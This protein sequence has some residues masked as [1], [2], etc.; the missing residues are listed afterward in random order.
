MK[1]CWAKPAASY[2]AP[3]DAPSCFNP[4]GNKQ[5]WLGLRLL[6]GYA[7]LSN[8]QYGDGKWAAAFGLVQMTYEH[9]YSAGGDSGNSPLQDYAKF[10]APQARRSVIEALQIFQESGGRTPTFGTYSTWPLAEY[11][12]GKLQEGVLNSADWP[13]TQGMDEM[14]A[15]L[16]KEPANGAQVPA[17]LGPGQVALGLGASGTRLEGPG[18][19]ISYNLLVP[20]TGTYAISLTSTEGGR[21]RACVNGV[22]VLQAATGQPHSLPP[23]FLTQGLH[24]L[25][26]VSTGGTFSVGEVTVAQAGALEGRPQLALADGDGRATASW[27]AVPGASGYLLGYGT[28][29]G[30]P[31]TLM[32]VGSAREH[33]LEGLANG[34]IYH[35]VV[36]AEKDGLLSLPSPEKSVK[37][38]AEGGVTELAV[39]DFQGLQGTEPSIEPTLAS[40]RATVSPLVRGA[41][42]LPPRS[43]FHFFANG[44]GAEAADN[45]YGKT[46]EEAVAGNDY[47]EFTVTPAPGRRLGLQQLKVYA[48]FQN[49]AA[50]KNQVGLTYHVEGGSPAPAPA[51]VGSAAGGPA[52]FTFDLAGIPALQDLAVPVV[53]RIHL[54]GNGPYEFCGLGGHSQ[55]P[56]IELTGTS[57]RP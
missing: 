7:K 31:Y 1:P 48:F 28:R 32:P 54:F 19:W 21:L 53:L 15:R 37:P 16:P 18:S 42:F 49:A 8:Y 35:A 41:G 56:D 9:G 24:N 20:R 13:L 22:D 46:L 36:F 39:W 10:A 55:G 40:S 51:A 25:R 57:A 14:L 26:L 4:S 3:R 50:G 17:L 43:N 47:F 44:A 38:V 12:E 34:T 45:T 6:T 2:A 5:A 29:P 23:Q 11:V 30:G 33:A 52:P 27:T